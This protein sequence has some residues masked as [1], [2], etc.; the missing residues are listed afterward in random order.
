MWL[1]S[2]YLMGYWHILQCFSTYKQKRLCD[3]TLC[4]HKVRHSKVLYD[5][6]RSG[7][8]DMLCMDLW[9][10]VLMKQWYWILAEW[11]CQGIGSG[12]LS[13]VMTGT[14]WWK[15]AASFPRDAFDNLKQRASSLRVVNWCNWLFN[16]LILM[17]WG[18]SNVVVLLW[19]FCWN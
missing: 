5:T 16:T 17:P 12:Q 3:L 10:T 1:H 9:Q 7:T 18:I 15:W 19:I 8:S 2:I 6:L 4:V 13:G 14:F 11:L